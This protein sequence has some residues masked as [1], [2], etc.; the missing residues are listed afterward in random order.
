MTNS[1]IGR[2]AQRTNIFNT[3]AQRTMQRSTRETRT[4]VAARVANLAARRDCKQRGQ[5]SFGGARFL[6]Y[7]MVLDSVHRRVC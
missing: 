2:F 4:A 7:A 1:R 5:S 3:F 6:K